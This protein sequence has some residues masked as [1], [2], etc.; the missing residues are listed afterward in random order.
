M[1]DSFKTFLVKDA[2]IG[3]ITPEL[4]YAVQSGAAQKTFQPFTST[5]ASNSS[6]SF[7]IQVP[8]ENV[9]VS[10][11]VLF[12]APLM[13]TLTTAAAGSTAQQC[14]LWG[15]DMAFNSFPLAMLQ[16]TATCTINNTATS[17]NVQDVL[18]PLLRL[19][20]SR[21]LYK[22]NSMTPSLPDQAYQSYADAV[23]GRN[24]NP[25]ADY[26]NV[27][28]D[29]DLL[30][31]GSFPCETFYYQFNSSGVLQGG[32]VQNADNLTA[33]AVGNYWKI[34]VVSQV[35][36]PIFLSPFIWGQPEN[37]CQGLLGISNFAFTFNIDSTLKRLVSY[38]GSLG[39]SIAPGGTI[40][41]G[42]SPVAVN[43]NLFQIAGVSQVGYAAPLQQP[44]LL[45]QFL[46]T[47]PT[48][49]LQTKNCVPYMDYPRYL[50][51]ATN[52]SSIDPGVTSRLSTSNIQINQIPDYIIV[53]VRK[54]MATQTIADA[55]SFFRIRDI[56]VN[57]NNASGLLSSA[58]TE[59]LWRISAKNGSTQNWL[60]FN[61]GAYLCDGTDPGAI[62]ATTGSILVLSPAMDLSLPSYLSNG[63]LGNFNLQMQISATNI[64]G[65]A[66]APE[67]MVICVN[68]GV[69]VTQQGV[70]SAYSGILTREMVLSAAQSKEWRSSVEDRRMT[71][72]KMLNRL[73]SRRPLLRKAMGMSAGAMSGGVR[74]GGKL[75][76][77]Y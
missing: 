33:L 42:G 51:P 17:M 1:A 76:G 28:Y 15:K 40:Y 46:S 72:G 24:N 25:V 43:T 52:T 3:D 22:H 56:S 7:N 74:S 31:R 29:V 14:P 16:Q 71:G 32:G 75:S 6:I 50:T 57:F 60:E 77:M 18:A 21:E 58:S 36:E 55:N 10:R 53:V 30:S 20:D 67:I 45:L 70:S 44:T 23:Q 27:S 34:V 5:S 41:S 12:Q 38:G 73:A 63:S 59:D 26:S 65:A 8:S 64:S 68:S 13:F 62:E 9:V 66:L 19:N 49:M 11:D 4:D 61:G 69:F 39:V 48:D 35:T 37:N 47:Q 2:T 54:P